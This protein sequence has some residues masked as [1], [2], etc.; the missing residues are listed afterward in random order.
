MANNWAP[1]ATSVRPRSAKSVASQSRVSEEDVTAST[2]GAAASVARAA[3]LPLGS[4]ADERSPDEEPLTRCGD[5]EAGTLGADVQLT[6]NPQPII[7]TDFNIPN[8]YRGPRRADNGHYSGSFDLG[9][10]RCIQQPNRSRSMSSGVSQS[11]ICASSCGVISSRDAESRS[12]SDASPW[13]PDVSAAST[14]ARVAA[15]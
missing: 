9:V 2:V 13:F 14:A 12:S 5:N 11:C 7:R 3:M 4:G 8:V 10:R 6:S 1:H 15:T